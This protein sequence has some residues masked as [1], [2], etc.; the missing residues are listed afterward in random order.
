MNLIISIN[1]DN[2]AFGD[3]EESPGFEVGRILKQLAE[4]YLAIG[5]VKEAAP[6]VIFDV[7]GNSVGT[8]TLEEN[9]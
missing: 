9:E 4:H 5:E 6:D 2:A 1:L 3:D 8:V 7:N